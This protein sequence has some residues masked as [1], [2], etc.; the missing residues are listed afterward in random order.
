MTD[1]ELKDMVASNIIWIKE[2]RKAQKQTDEQMKK[3]DEQFKKSDKKWQKI[4]DKIDHLWELYWNSE[5]NKWAEVEDYFFRYFKKH[6]MLPAR[7]HWWIKFDQ[8]DRWRIT[9][10]NQ[11]HDIV[12][13]NG[14]SSALI[15][16]KYR[17]TIANVDDFINRE[18][19]KLK[20]FLKW[21]WSKHKLY[22]W[23][24]TFILDDKVEEYAK[25]MW[26]YVFIRKWEDTKII[27]SK[28]F[29]AKEF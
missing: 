22:W 1:K 8:V 24:A 6:K 7:K 20:R 2:L 11:E 26:L 13:I 23:V 19:H 21:V 3:T 29:E 25:E 28:D 16:V 10:D 12:M 9:T 15:S 17:L 4:S 14:K 5:N 27:N 18:V